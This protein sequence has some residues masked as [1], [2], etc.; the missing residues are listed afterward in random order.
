MLK[1]VRQIRRPMTPFALT[2]HA[3]CHFSTTM[4]TMLL[5]KTTLC[6]FVPSMSF[7]FPQLE[8]YDD[9]Q[10][11][12]AMAGAACLGLIAQVCASFAPP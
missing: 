5:R 3:A 10:F 4:C 12:V 1:Q 7:P 11:T 6:V 2:P 9:D 8:D